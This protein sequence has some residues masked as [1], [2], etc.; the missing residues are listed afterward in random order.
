MALL[1]AGCGSIQASSKP[2]H[3]GGAVASGIL[4]LGRLTLERP[5]LA[6]VAADTLARWHRY[7]LSTAIA[8]VP[9]RFGPARIALSAGS[10]PL[11][12]TL[13]LYDSAAEAT[14]L[15]RSLRRDH[16]ARETRAA[17]F[18]LYVGARDLAPSRFAMLFDVAEAR[19][20]PA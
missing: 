9:R 1:V 13:Y 18:C 5:E 20:H 16:V 2:G 12:M 4:A 7:G 8:A 15:R 10:A 14:R 6:R 17:G 19:T 3:R 11:R